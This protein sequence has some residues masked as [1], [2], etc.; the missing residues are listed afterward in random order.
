MGMQ[1]LISWVECANIKGPNLIQECVHSIY[2]KYLLAS[3]G[4]IEW[5]PIIL[6]PED[7]MAV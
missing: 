5:R 6:L 2:N 7:F 1:E 4:R 3:D